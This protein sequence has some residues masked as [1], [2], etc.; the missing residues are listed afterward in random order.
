MYGENVFKGIRLI[1]GVPSVGETSDHYFYVVVDDSKPDTQI[2]Y[3]D[4]YHN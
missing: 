2:Y 4:H 3:Q 1:R